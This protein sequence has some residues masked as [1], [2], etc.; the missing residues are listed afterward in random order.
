R[1]VQRRLSKSKQLGRTLER[2][3]YAEIAPARYLFP[4]A[5]SEQR[6]EALSRGPACRGI[7]RDLQIISAIAGGRRDLHLAVGIK[8]ECRLPGKG[9]VERGDHVAD[10][11]AGHWDCGLANALAVRPLQQE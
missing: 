7:E 2:R 5:H 8:S 10:R 1:A 3:G 6:G 11:G 4:D 9:G